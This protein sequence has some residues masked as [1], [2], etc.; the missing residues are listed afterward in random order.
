MAAI[1]LEQVTKEY[2]SR[3]HPVRALANLD[4]E[5]AAGE[6]VAIVGPSGCGKTTTLRLVAGLEVPSA[7]II[8]IAGR[9]M[10]GVAPRE[11]DVAMVM[12]DLA[13]FPH[14][15]VRDNLGF[16][17]RMR[18]APQTQIESRVRE[19]VSLLRL[20]PLLER[21]PG[22]L[23]GGEAQRVALGRAF[24]RRPRVFLLDEPLASLDAQLRMQLRGEIKL[25]QRRSE[26]AMLYVTH[27]QEEAMSLGDRIAVLC[28]GVLQQM[29]T[30]TEIYGRPANR[31]VAAFLG[32]PPMNLIRGRLEQSD[33]DL[34][35]HGPAGA[36]RMPCAALAH[37][38]SACEVVLGIRPHEW[39]VVG[40][41][42]ETVPPPSSGNINVP[43]LEGI[44]ARVEPLGDAANVWLEAGDM[45]LVAR[46]P[47]D[48]E[49]PP[50]ARV[51][52]HADLRRAHLFA[53]DAAGRR[54]N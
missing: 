39:Q 42:P 6:L 24:V 48:Y 41:A 54:L 50:G 2:P 21:R 34:W 17:L 13:L 14:L 47:A 45:E 51:A 38:S 49:L 20:E 44:I 12:Q 37:N 23:S 27:D 3:R 9:D 4:L 52:L 8:R 19:A 40:R 36:W 32:S 16:G 5:A 31:F 7:G 26:T 22:A 28:G 53:A 35:F 11:R 10:A 1:Q 18:N 30:P 29:G 15:S 25:L 33:G 46:V 43:L